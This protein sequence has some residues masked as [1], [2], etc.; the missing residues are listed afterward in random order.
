MHFRAR[1]RGQAHRAS[2]GVPST[3]PACRFA[4]KLRVVHP[5]DENTSCFAQCGARHVE[6]STLPCQHDI[7]VTS[8]LP[9]KIN[10]VV[11]LSL[12]A[13]HCA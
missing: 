13:E 1:K 11:S 10:R 5:A 9:K 6:L 12:D 7:G 2:W 4:K 3:E 8:D